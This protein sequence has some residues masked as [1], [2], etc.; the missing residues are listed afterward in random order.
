M[1]GPFR[2]WYV[3]TQSVLKE[4]AIHQVIIDAYQRRRTRATKQQMF[5]H[6]EH[7]TTYGDVSSMK[8][9]QE[10]IVQIEEQRTYIVA[11]NSHI[12][13]LVETIDDLDVRLDE[14]R[15]LTD[16]HSKQ[17]SEAQNKSLDYQH[18]L[19]SVE[20]QYMIAQSRLDALTALHPGTANRIRGE[21][22]KIIDEKESTKLQRDLIDANL[23]KS[24]PD[25]D[26]SLA[27]LVRG[28]PDTVLS[29]V[30]SL[31]MH[32]ILL[33]L[34]SHYCVRALLTLFPTIRLP[35]RIS[36]LFLSG[37][38]EGEDPKETRQAGQ[39]PRPRRWRARLHTPPT[40][41]RCYGANGSIAIDFS[42]RL[43][44]EHHFGWLSSGLCVQRALRDAG[45]RG[46]Y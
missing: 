6:W 8:S 16:S 42:S 36:H 22:Q 17:R 7:M 45:R 23:G 19:K 40:Q 10:M 39:F 5:K 1:F 14:E 21:E 20:E 27:P 29:P 15:A 30:G 3:L 33:S 11:L 44:V 46:R 4:R 12:V 43:Q 9:R 24:T 31:F 37:A 13:T 32:A 26:K 38:V 41:P 2:A 28:S 18:A 25:M 35:F 34:S